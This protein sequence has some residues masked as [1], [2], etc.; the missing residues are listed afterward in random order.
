MRALQISQQS[1]SF[2]LIIAAKIKGAISVVIETRRSEIIRQFRAPMLNARSELADRFA[3]H[4]FT[5]PSSSKR[6]P[7]SQSPP[8]AN[9][10]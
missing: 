3:Y 10:R 4:R 9:L 1:V 2:R 6:L 8:M 5:S 7:L